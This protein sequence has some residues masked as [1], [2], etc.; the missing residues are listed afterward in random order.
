[1][2]LDYIDGVDVSKWQDPI[3][4]E[5]LIASGFK[6]II[7]RVG[8]GNY[9]DPRF[10]Q[11]YAEAHKRD[12]PHGVGWYFYVRTYRD[13][14]EQLN[15]IKEQLAGLPEPTLSPCPGWGFLDCEHYTSPDQAYNNTSLIHNLSKYLA[16]EGHY[17]GI[18]TRAEWWNSNVLRESYWSIL[19]LWLAHWQVNTPKLP[20]DWKDWDIWQYDSLNT[21]GKELGVGSHGLDLN[22]IKK[23]EESPEPPVPPAITYPEQF[24]VVLKLDDKRWKGQVNL[25]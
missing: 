3:N 12:W 17:A 11:W 19:P 7:F 18:Y 14:N 5:K 13:V 9:K 10:R 20:E 16:Q 8:D 25:Q 6:Y 15:L 2:T 24:E 21:G 22:Y 23:K 4:Q 1:M